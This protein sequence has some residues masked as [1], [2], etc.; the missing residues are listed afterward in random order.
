MPEAHDTDEGFVLEGPRGPVRAVAIEDAVH[1][2]LGV[3]FDTPPRGLGLLLRQVLGE[4]AAAHTD[5][6]GVYVYPD[7]ARSGAS[8]Y[9]G[10]VADL[11]EGGMWVR[12]ARAEEADEPVQA[13]AASN[14]DLLSA[15]QGLVG[16]NV[17]A[18]L[19]TALADP[20]GDPMAALA[21]LASKLLEDPALHQTVQSAAGTMIHGGHISDPRNLDPRG[22]LAQAKSIAERLS[23]EQ[24]DLVASLARRIGV[25]EDAED[26]EEE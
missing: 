4:A 9:E 7:I 3:P 26:T 18:Q 11:G 15:V 21:G 25:T 23:S 1:L 13:A 19:Q 20:D 6:R 10:V 24:P 14:V 5:E 2:H 22:L 17:V 12:L 16:G 8:T